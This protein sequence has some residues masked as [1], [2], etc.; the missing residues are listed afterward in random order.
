M[1]SATNA[2]GR[3]LE[4]TTQGWSDFASGTMIAGGRTILVLPIM[5]IQSFLIQV[6]QRFHDIVKCLLKLFLPVPVLTRHM[7]MLVVTFLPESVKLA[8]KVS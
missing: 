4:C 3:L 1:K 6:M 2:I 5:N 8:S 7:R